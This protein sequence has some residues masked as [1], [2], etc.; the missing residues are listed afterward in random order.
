MVGRCWREWR[1]RAERTLLMERMVE[2]RALRMEEE[3]EV[4]REVN[5]EGAVDEV[6]EEEEGKVVVRWGG[7]VVG[8]RKGREKGMVVLE[9]GMRFFVGDSG[10]SIDDVLSNEGVVF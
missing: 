6:V 9:L 7:G 8:R 3:G 4:E 10:G 2:E 1:R 5:G